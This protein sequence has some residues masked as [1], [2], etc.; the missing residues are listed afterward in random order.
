M[1]EPSWR[2]F[3]LQG[4]L[5]CCAGVSLWALQAGGCFGPEGTSLLPWVAIILVQKSILDGIILACILK[6]HLKKAKEFRASV[7]PSNPRCSWCFPYSLP[8]A[9]T[10][11]PVVTQPFP[12]S[13]VQPPK[14][15]R[16]WLKYMWK[17]LPFWVLFASFQ[18]DTCPFN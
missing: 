12:L 3:R 15:K 2:W 18:P 1:L 5:Q 6:V 4:F 8:A 7:P 10:S 13:H 11:T 9:G 16:K 14:V 17:P